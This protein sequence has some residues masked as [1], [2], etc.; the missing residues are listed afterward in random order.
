MMADTRSERLAEIGRARAEL[1]RWTGDADPQIEGP[2][3]DFA[4]DPERLRSGLDLHPMVKM[5]GAQA[6]QADADVV[7]ARAE[8]R[9]DF[10]VDV[11]Y[12][13]RDP[14]FGDYVSAGV[15]V[16]LPLFARHRQ[17][18]LIAAASAKASATRAEQA[19]T[20]QA[21][22]AELD[23]D[24]ADHVMHHDQWMRARDTLQPL[25]EERVALETASYGAGRASLTDVVDAHVALA[26]AILTTLDR[27][28]TV[29]SDAA[30][31]TLSFQTSGGSA[32]Q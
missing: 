25:A 30:R 29:A 24:L 8:K 31:L 6:G 19:A 27:E 23:A 15:T 28:A 4:L 13:R 7:L 18:P 5:V 11:A 21:L 32:N 14:R 1:T 16:S 2:L 3:P 12:Q 26:D 22:A 10:G 20:R 17:D 9:P